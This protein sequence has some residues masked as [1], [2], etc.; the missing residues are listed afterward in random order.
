MG[1]LDQFMTTTEAAHEGGFRNH[2]S[3]IQA[4]K[5]HKLNAVRKGQRYFI[6]RIEFERWMNCENHR[7]KANPN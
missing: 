2:R 5:R 4:I 7:N 3:I 1:T 6:E